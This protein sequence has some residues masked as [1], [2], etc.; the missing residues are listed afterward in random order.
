MIVLARMLETGEDIPQLLQAWEERRYD[1]CV[2]VQEGS[3]NTG[4]R[5]H[6]PGEEAMRKAHDHIRAHAQSDLNARLVRLNQ[7]M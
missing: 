4:V 3:K 1:R 6:A 5:G 2:F 7:P